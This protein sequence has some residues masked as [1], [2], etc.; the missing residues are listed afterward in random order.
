M[1]NIEKSHQQI[2]NSSNLIK[3]AWFLNR[4]LVHTYGIFYDIV[5]KIKFKILEQLFKEFDYVE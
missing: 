5:G 3:N 2:S 4:I 1:N